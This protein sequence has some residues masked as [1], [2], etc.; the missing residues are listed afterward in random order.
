MVVGVFW[1][2]KKA[3]TR[4][5]DE[6]QARY[7][8]RFWNF[9]SWRSGF[10]WGFQLV[11][12]ASWSASSEGRPGA[13]A[14][15]A[16]PDALQVGNHSVY[17]QGKQRVNQGFHTCSEKKC[18]DGPVSCHTFLLG[19]D[20]KTGHDV[21][22]LGAVHHQWAGAALWLGGTGRRTRTQTER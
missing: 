5:N 22:A 18:T 6:R 19:S 15:A 12:D 3:S 2:T 16:E 21:E 8:G 20:R 4:G 17:C 11:S 13:R 7:R 10:L 9:A 14:V 1:L